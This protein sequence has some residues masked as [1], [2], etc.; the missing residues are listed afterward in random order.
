MKQYVY[1]LL[2]VLPLA[3]SAQPVLQVVQDFKVGTSAKYK[4]CAPVAPGANGAG[5]T[6][7]FTSLTAL[8][9]MDTLN[10]SYLAA[11]STYAGANVLE[12]TSDSVSHYMNISGNTNQTV[13]YADSSVAGMNITNVYSNTALAMQ[14]PLSYGLNVTDT[15]AGNL[16]FSGY[17]LPTS[18]F[19]T[20]N[21][22]VTGYGIL[23]VPGATYNDVLKVRVEH[24]QTSSIATP[25]PILVNLTIVSYMWFDAMHKSPLLRIDSML[26]NG[27]PA[28]PV[29]NMARNSTSY[30]LSETYP[31]NIDN[32][33]GSN[34]SFN[35]YIKG[36][37]LTL[38][39]N[40]SQN[41]TYNIA[42]TN[43]AGQTVFNAEFMPTSPLN[44]FDTGHD[45]PPAM[46]LITV[47]EK[48][49]MLSAGT[50]K[51]IK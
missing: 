42:V 38:E 47:Q 45:L 15:F 50:I 25:G 6:W 22:D 14:R 19:N 13:A 34:I 16:L 41:K 2:L 17:T 43:L 24:K 51:I 18:G 12:K 5:I 37:S 49:N 48:G 30:L 46:Y 8:G 31:Q 1:S 26:V 21:I 23:Y 35:A 33:Y 28:P 7:N 9:G 44:Q 27:S 20:R 29:P 36:T 39:A 3:A 32:V 11:G 10:V 40:L 4:K